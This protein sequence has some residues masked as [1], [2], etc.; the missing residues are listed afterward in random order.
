[1]LVCELSRTFPL[2]V[3]ATIEP[4]T[5][6]K[7]HRDTRYRRE[8]EPCIPKRKKTLFKTK[9]SKNNT[10]DFFFSFDLYTLVVLAGLA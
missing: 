3:P 5:P 7:G 9:I 10:T 6:L 8:P 1:M 2:H 4:S